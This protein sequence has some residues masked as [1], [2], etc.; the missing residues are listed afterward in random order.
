M[1]PYLTQSRSFVLRARTRNGVFWRSAILTGGS[2]IC[3]SIS[4][5]LSALFGLVFSIFLLRPATAIFC[6]L[7]LAA[8]L[9]QGNLNIFGPEAGEPAIEFILVWAALFLSALLIVRGDW[10]IGTVTKITLI[11]AGLGGL[12]TLATSSALVVSIFALAQF[13]VPL[14]ALSIWLDNLFRPTTCAFEAPYAVAGVLT[15][16]AFGCIGVYVVGNGYEYNK[17]DFNGLAWQPQIVGLFLAPLAVLILYLRRL[18]LWLR[19]TILTVS[20]GLIWLAW[21]R[22]G[23]GGLVLVAAIEATRFALKKLWKPA[24]ASEG[25]GKRLRRSLS[26]LGLGGL[27]AA[28]VIGSLWYASGTSTAVI[29]PDA[30]SQLFNLEGYTASRGMPIAR[31]YGNIEGHLATGIGFGVPSDP[32]LLDPYTAIENLRIL[33]TEGRFEIL[34]DKGN[35]YVAIFEE[36]GLLGAPIWLALFFFMLYRVAETGPVG[37]ALAIL[38]L[39]CALGEAIVFSVSGIGLLHWAS[40]IAAAGFAKQPRRRV[41]HLVPAEYTYDKLVKNRRAEDR[42]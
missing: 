13:L 16:F 26:R 32:R 10:R 15:A 7:G 41:S 21:S 27:Y 2:L 31:S 24:S 20:V 14:C 3:L 12:I 25:S 22:T 29:K 34:I 30:P 38:F 11:A 40:L 36:A 35:S 8:L 23:L 18:S 9:P 1:E 42:N 39:V 19:L 37:R 17:V 5:W 6:L 4:P 33:K 28:C